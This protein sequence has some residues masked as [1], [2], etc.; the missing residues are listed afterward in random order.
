MT[1]NRAQLETQLIVDESKSLKVYRDNRGY[2]T[3]GIGH[4]VTKHDA[5]V[6]GQVISEDQCEM[7][8]NID[9]DIAVATC[10]RLIPNFDELPETAQQVLANMAFNLGETKLKQFRNTLDAAEKQQW[11]RMATQMR[12]S[13]WYFQV[14]NRSKRLVAKIMSL[15]PTQKD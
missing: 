11:A 4:L 14:G 15:V 5:L 7:L 3:A 12:A 1:M 6:Y 8:F 10:H 13:A 9:V 2:L